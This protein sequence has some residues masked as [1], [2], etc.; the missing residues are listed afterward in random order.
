MLFIKSVIRG[1][2]PHLPPLKGKNPPCKSILLKSYWVLVVMDQFT[3]R[4]AGFGVH[5]GDVH[6]AAL[7]RM[8][9]A[10]TSSRGAPPNVSALITIRYCLITNGRR[11]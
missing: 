4:I 1:Q 9:N 10:A 7:C 8:F 2:S 5:L 6:G 3:R 11:T